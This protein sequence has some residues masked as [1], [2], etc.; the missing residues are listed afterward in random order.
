MANPS[1]TGPSPNKYGNNGNRWWVG[2][3]VG[4]TGS[5]KTLLGGASIVQPLTSKPSGYESLPSGN[6]GDDAQFAAAAK[7]NKKNSKPNTISVQNIKWFNIQG[8]FTTQDAANAAIPGIQKGAPAEG[9][10][11]QEAGAGNGPVSKGA[12]AISSAEG[13]E[14]ALGNATLWIRV[15]K[16]AVGGAIL[17]VGLAKLTGADKAIGGVA[18]KAVK[19]APFL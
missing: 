9:A 8:P 1:G 2:Q 10:V 17:L 6:A 19:V 4:E 12:A 18:S 7:N 14:S 15:A 13:L 16:V 3:N 5:Q 11:K